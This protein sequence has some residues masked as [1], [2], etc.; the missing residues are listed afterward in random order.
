MVEVS[1]CVVVK[2]FAV[3]K[4]EDPGNP[5]EANDALPNEASDISLCDNSQWF[6]LD[7]FS[8]VVDPY[9]EELELSYSD[10]ERSH[11]I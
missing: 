4:D 6:G 11:Y 9:D 3:V 5:E 10:R 1:K 2:F 8:K 7:P